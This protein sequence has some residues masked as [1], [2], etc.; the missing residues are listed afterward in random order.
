M[1]TET[2]GPILLEQESV[3]EVAGADAMTFLQGQLSQDIAL[4]SSGAASIAGLSNPKG[5]L[6]AVTHVYHASEGV[7]WLILPSTMID[8]VFTNLT[9]YIFRSK[10]ELKKR[11]DLY[12]YGHLNSDDILSKNVFKF[13]N[14]SDLV[15]SIEKELITNSNNLHKT[16]WI[17]N[18]IR[19]GIPDIYPVTSEHFVAQMLNLDLLNGISFSK[20]CYTGQEIIAR[21]QHLGRIKRRMLLLESEND[22]EPGASVQI[23]TQNIGEVVNV[24]KANGK[25][26]LLAVI[27]LDAWSKIDSAIRQ[28]QYRQ[29][30]LPYKVQS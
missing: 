29:L 5:R 15:I 4:I 9:K 19:N 13:S 27:K 12:L 25:Q 20:G 11:N 23:A 24:V 17:E 2:L 7:Y 22:L 16:I 14:F 3:L 26:L 30:E 10:V 28:S 6:I 1:T 18:K 21:M 8:S